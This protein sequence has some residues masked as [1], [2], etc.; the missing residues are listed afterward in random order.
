MVMSTESG[1]KTL[2]E[3]FKLKEVALALVK[4]RC[5][6]RDGFGCRG[7]MTPGQRRFWLS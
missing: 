1:F 3:L 5:C 7:D 4:V 2:S 6:D